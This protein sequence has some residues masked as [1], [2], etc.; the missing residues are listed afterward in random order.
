MSG[1]T[2]EQQSA[3]SELENA[4]AKLFASHVSPTEPKPK[5]ATRSSGAFARILENAKAIQAKIHGLLQLILPEKFADSRV[6]DGGSTVIAVGAFGLIVFVSLA[7]KVTLTVALGFFVVTIL[8]GL[9]IKILETNVSSSSLQ[10][11]YPSLAAGGVIAIAAKAE[12]VLDVVLD[13]FR[14]WKIQFHESISFILRVVLASSVMA[15]LITG[16]KGTIASSKLAAPSFILAASHS[17]PAPSRI[18]LFSFHTFF[19]DSHYGD[20]SGGWLSLGLQ[21]HGSI[22][23]QAHPYE[24]SYTNIAEML[25]RCASPSHPVKVRINGYSSPRQ[26]A[27]NDGTGRLVDKQFLLRSIDRD[28]VVTILDAREQAI[29]RDRLSTLIGS[30]GVAQARVSI[31]EIENIR[32]SERAENFAQAFNLWIAEKRAHATYCK[33]MKHIDKSIDCRSRFDGTNAIRIEIPTITGDYEYQNML[34]DIPGY[35]AILKGGASDQFA[36]AR[37]SEIIVENAGTCAVPHSH[38][39]VEPQSVSQ[40]DAGIL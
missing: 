38:H 16:V 23:I 2:K 39:R 37:S 24:L 9:V 35:E 13:F 4:I 5:D 15:L 10:F 22:S 12:Q 34:E 31:D 11:F 1:P 18:G 32:L 29:T 28:S 3:Y 17:S 6:V 25:L 33:L 27:Q 14:T 20:L 26:W 19:T 40:N 7:F 30:E 36:F 8:P 21:S